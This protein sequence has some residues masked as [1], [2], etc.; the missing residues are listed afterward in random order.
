MFRQCLKRCSV[1]NMK[2]TRL[3]GHV[4]SFSVNYN[5]IEIDD[6]HKYLKKKHNIK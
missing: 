3:H 5:S 4:Y 2:K 6:V 1:D